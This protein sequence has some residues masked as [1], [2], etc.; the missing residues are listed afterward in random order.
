[1]LKTPL[2]PTL[3][4]M[5][6]EVGATPMLSSTPLMQLAADLQGIAE[7][8]LSADLRGA[9]TEIRRRLV[10]ALHEARD[11]DRWISIEHAA[12]LIDRPPTTIRTWCRDGRVAARKVGGRAWQVDR[13]SLVARRPEAA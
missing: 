5:L 11:L 12:A 3:T 7:A 8:Q 6:E 13:H 9:I 1:M 2:D 10:R 4:A